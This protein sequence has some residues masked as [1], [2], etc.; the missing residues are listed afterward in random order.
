MDQLAHY[1]PGLAG[2]AILSTN[3]GD[4]EEIMK[5]VVDWSLCDGNALCTREAPDFL[6]VDAQ[7]TLHVMKTTF[8][9]EDLARVQR[10]VQVCPK[11]ALSIVD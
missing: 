11:C 6:A 5:L 7:D 2:S 3:R 9:A 4:P 10:A 1:H 8:E